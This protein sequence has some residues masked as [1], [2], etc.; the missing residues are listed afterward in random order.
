MQFGIFGVGVLLWMLY[1]HLKNAIQTRSIPYISLVVTTIISIV[2][3]SEL[4]VTVFYIP[5]YGYTIMLL[6]LYYA[7][8]DKKEF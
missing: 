1:T 4:F 6:S 3:V 8:E 7:K 5:F 2:S